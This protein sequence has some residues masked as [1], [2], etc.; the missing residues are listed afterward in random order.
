MIKRINF[1]QISQLDHKWVKSKINEFIKE[2]MPDGDI[3][4]NLT[5]SNDKVVSSKMIAMES[6]IFCG[7]EYLPSCF[8]ETCDIKVVAKDG[9]IVESGDVLVD[10]DGPA[11]Q[12]LTFERVIL[13]LTQRL[14]GISTETDKYCKLN[15]PE[16]FKVMDTR[17]TTPGLRLFEKHAVSVG[18]G[19]NHRLDLS[20]AILIKDNHIQAAGSIEKTLHSIKIE[21]K[22][23][24]PIELE[25]DTIN[26]LKEGLKYDL[27][28]FLLD[29][30]K[31]EEVRKCVELIRKEPEGDTYFIEA[32]G[33]INYDTLE[34][35][36]ETGIDGVSMSAIT[37]NAPSVDIKLEF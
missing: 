27:D 25:V 32:S 3:T 23:D 5:I 31:P 35:Y 18:G 13:N 6:F 20:S 9:E 19:W 26:Q 4:T 24:L 28:G 33:G 10:I 14:C 2:D 8:P 17:K 11:N 29:N 21:D 37:A 34:S 1:K 30:M 12:I 36:A 7:E 15:L 22:R 16:G